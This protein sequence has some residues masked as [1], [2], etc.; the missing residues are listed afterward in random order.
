METQIETQIETMTTTTR[1]QTTQPFLAILSNIVLIDTLM[2]EKN[3][4][5]IHTGRHS[6][7]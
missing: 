1:I 6:L 3:A 5:T 4:C 7:I 2:V